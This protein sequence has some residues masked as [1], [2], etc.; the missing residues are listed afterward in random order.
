L[1]I[2]WPT[3]GCRSVGIVRSRTQTMEFSFYF[4]RS[5]LGVFMCLMCIR[6][7]HFLG[8]DFEVIPVACGLIAPCGNAIKI[9]GRDQRLENVFFFLKFPATCPTSEN[10]VQRHKILHRFIF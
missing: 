4:R 9:N 5:A 1:A 8:D 3:S 7:R 2:T 6:H 10:G